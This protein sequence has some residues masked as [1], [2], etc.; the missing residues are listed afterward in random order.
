MF[1]VCKLRQFVIVGI[2]G[3]CEYKELDGFYG[4]QSTKLYYNF[5]IIICNIL[6]MYEV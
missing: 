1:N 5:G 3:M 6:Y 2:V 4:V